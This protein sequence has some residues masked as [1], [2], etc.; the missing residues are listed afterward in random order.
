MDGAATPSQADF[1]TDDTNPFEKKKKKKKKKEKKT[2]A[3]MESQLADAAAEED[4]V[5]DFWSD[6]KV[7]KPSTALEVVLA[8]GPTLCPA[9]P[10]VCLL[11][12]FDPVA[13]GADPQGSGAPEENGHGR[14]SRMTSGGGRAIQMGV[15]ESSF[16]LPCQD[17]RVHCCE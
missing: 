2:L 14:S 13:R 9:V 16:C 3:R 5:A 4:D 15:H 1:Q 6:G 12:G 11:H 10:A 7:E 8:S 17:L